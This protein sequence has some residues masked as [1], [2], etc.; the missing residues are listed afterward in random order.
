MVTQKSIKLII[1]AGATNQIGRIPQIP[2]KEIQL[3][4]YTSHLRY[5]YITE[6]FG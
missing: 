5:F 3:E 4:T 6:S 2:A 1:P